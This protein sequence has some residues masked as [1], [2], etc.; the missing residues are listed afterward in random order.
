MST[1]SFR[2]DATSSAILCFFVEAVATEHLEL[3]SNDP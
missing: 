1:L 2:I 3:T